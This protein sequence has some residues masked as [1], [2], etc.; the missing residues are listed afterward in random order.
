MTTKKLTTIDLHPAYREALARIKDTK[1]IS[2][3][4]QIHQGLKKFFAE[5]KDVV[6]KLD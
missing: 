2:Y 1:G 4:A 3:N 6:G 5:H